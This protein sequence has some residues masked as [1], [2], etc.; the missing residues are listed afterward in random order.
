MKIKKKSFMTRLTQQLGIKDK[1]TIL[2][3]HFIKAELK[4]KISI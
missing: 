3:H 4:K 2:R 1:I